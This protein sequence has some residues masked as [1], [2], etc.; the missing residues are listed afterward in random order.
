MKSYQR[1]VL[2]VA[3]NWLGDAVMSLPLIGCLSAAPGL[4]LTVM[5]P[6]Y[7]ARVFSCLDEVGDLIV[8]PK[9]GPFRGLTRRSRTIRRIACD[10]GVLL[11]PSFSSALSLFVSGVRCRV[12]YAA[13]GRGFLLS[14]PVPST[15]LREEHLSENYLR[16]GRR[17][18]AR[19]ELADVQAPVRPVLK[20]FAAERES[21]AK[22]LRS[23]GAPAVNYAVVVPGAAYGPTKSWP[24]EKY[25]RLAT[26]LSKEVPVVLAGSPGDRA[27]CDSISR[28]VTGVVNLA[29]LTSLG[30]FFALLATARVVVANDSG[31]PH[32]AGSLGVPTVVIFGSTSPRWTKPLGPHVVVV[33]EHV[34]CSP[35]FLRECPTQLECYRGIEPGRVFDIALGSMNKAVEAVPRV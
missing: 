30:E 3:P 34:H 25:R 9:T 2:V 27:L 20:V 14:E 19:L 8:L 17:L 18:L 21:V 33:R 22:M 35:C 11:P 10:G 23:H 31:A 5:A 26:M 7:T 16:L 4:R 29:G 1:S 28:D 12:G 32:V 24:A 6:P 15:K 13:D